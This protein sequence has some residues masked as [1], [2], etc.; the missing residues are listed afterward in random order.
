[1]EFNLRDG[2][3]NF[4]HY[5]ASQIRD[6]EPHYRSGGGS[7]AAK[8]FEPCLRYCTRYRRAAGYFSSTAL[9]T[10][11]GAL[12]RLVSDE[13]MLVE[14]ITSPHLSAEDITTLQSVSEDNTR[15][16]IQNEIIKRAIVDALKFIEN[17]GDIQLRAKLFAWL[18][19][20]ERLILRFAFSEKIEFPGIFHEKIGIFEFPWFDSIAFTGSANET[21]G[22]H[23]RNYESIDVFRS[24]IDGDVARIATKSEQFD[25][26]WNNNAN[27]LE[28]LRLSPSLLE[29]VR[30]F[31]PSE[32]PTQIHH[33]IT[34][35]EPEDRPLWDHQTIAMERFIAAK[36][37]VL[38]MATGTGK[39]RTALAIIE[40][41]TAAG[42]IGSVIVSTE[43]TDLLEQWVDELRDWS[44]GH[45]P[46]FVVYRHYSKFHELGEFALE[47]QASMIV[48]SRAKL[49][50]LLQ[51]IGSMSRRNIL[52]VHDE[53]HGLG[54]P[55]IRTQLTGEH[56]HFKYRLGLS[57]TPERYYDD[58]GNKFLESE[59][60]PTVYRFL[61]ENA[62]AK[63]ILCEFD[64]VPLDYDLTDND[65][66]RIQMVYARRAA[67][68]AEGNPM[69]DEE[70]WI[71]ISKVYKTAEM[72]PSI[73]A[74]YLE[75]DSSCI[76][77][78]IIF[79]ETKEYGGFVLPLLHSKTHLYRTYYAEDEHQH[80]ID[81]FDGNIQCLVT[82]H[83]ISQGIDIRSLKN[84]ILFSS[85]RSKLETIQRIGRCLRVDPNNPDKR[86]R[87]I[88]FVRPSEAGEKSMNAD[89]ERFAW[90]E[91]VSKVKKGD[92]IAT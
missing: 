15:I 10:W 22:G 31:S 42:D 56:Q 34:P 41:L 75:K 2:M 26:A 28:V 21:L 67:R 45:E 66:D 80:L 86:A 11:S 19:A 5:P 79:V 51:R 7:L 83:R 50:S 17:P 87:I 68:K 60:G 4:Q 64:Y 92:Q 40:H 69:S 43:G 47:P 54:T 49:G 89:Q 82:C 77:N 72:K 52:I 57:A 46:R 38:E 70:V 58:E 63:G 27:G 44:I 55:A 78:S 91:A 30:D 16:K 6:L 65:R 81:F 13:N 37:G 48:I 36:N 18:V 9:I 32:P 59:I 3:E 12:Q 20:N 25:E 61:L 76:E 35:P 85:A 8:F 29:R 14:L 39:T 23:Q 88:D 84:V 53:V 73:F 90:L 74:D 71:E 1:M 62:I 24:W 33:H